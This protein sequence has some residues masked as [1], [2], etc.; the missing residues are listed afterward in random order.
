MP[1]RLPLQCK[2]H[3]RLL[4]NELNPHNQQQQLLRLHYQ[5]SGH[6]HRINV[7]L[8]TGQAPTIPRVLQA[9]EVQAAMFLNRILRARTVYRNRNI[10]HTI[11]G[12]M[13]K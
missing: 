7:C 8:T 2:T 9:Q 12:L 11:P 6:L 1:A 3:A 4:H 10:R 13:L 5:A